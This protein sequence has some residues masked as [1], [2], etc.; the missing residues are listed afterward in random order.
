M[1]F[2]F[3][4]GR[5]DIMIGNRLIFGHR[6]FFREPFGWTFPIGEMEKK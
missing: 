4:S 2:H 5:H 6:D 3:T 1:H